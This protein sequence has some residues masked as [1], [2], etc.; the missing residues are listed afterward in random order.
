MNQAQL[1]TVWQQRRL[2][3]PGVPLSRPLSVLMKFTLGKRVRQLGAL[4]GIW[5]DVLPEF[6]LEH[7]ALEGFRRGVLTVVVDSAAHRFR[8]QTLLAGGLEAEIRRRFSGALNKVR[9]VP[10]QFVEMDPPRRAPAE[11]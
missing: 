5:Q 7:T 1:R 4:A 6:L 9:L 2:P 10:G 11:S 8:L 3:E